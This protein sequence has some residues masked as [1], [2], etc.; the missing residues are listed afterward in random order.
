MNTC[1]ACFVRPALASVCVASLVTLGACG[2]NSCIGLGDCGGGNTVPNITLSGTAATGSAL[3]SATVNFSCAQGAGSALSDGGGHY[4]ITFDAT[5]P[6]VITA[7]SG[8]ISLHSLA[9]AGG[10]FNTSPET[11][12]MMVYLASQLGT[13]EASLI[14]AFPNNAQF[15]RT[16]AN[17]ADVLAAQSAVVSNLQGRYA[18]TLTAPTFLTTPFV[19]GQ[20]GVDRDL[21]ALARAGAIDTNGMPDQAAVALLSAAGLAHPLTATPAS[22]SSTGTGSTSGA[23]GGMM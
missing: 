14:S 8:S 7:S 18:L 13:N 3:A 6:C 1:Y 9:F 15:Q 22:S 2:G 5:P 10:T 16:L 19:V 20:A 12:L 21:D 23:T 17:Q 11:E 4:A